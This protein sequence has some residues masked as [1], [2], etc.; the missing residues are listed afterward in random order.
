MSVRGHF[1]GDYSLHEP[2]DNDGIGTSDF[3]LV[4]DRFHRIEKLR[5]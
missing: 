3:L 5:F 4:A 1:I 2:G